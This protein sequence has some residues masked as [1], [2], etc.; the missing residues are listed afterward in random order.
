MP[1]LKDLEE[2]GSATKDT[3]SL[4]ALAE[5]GHAPYLCDLLP[6]EAKEDTNGTFRQVNEWIYLLCSKERE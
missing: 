6:L 3:L 2:D 4:K 1:T 5:K